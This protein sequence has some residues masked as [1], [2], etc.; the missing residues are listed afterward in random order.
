MFIHIT[1][2]DF[3][4]ENK[5][6][7]ILY[8]GTSMPSWKQTYDNISLLYLSNEQIEA[9]NYAYETAANDEAKGIKPEPILCIIDLKTLK[10]IKEIEFHPDWGGYEVDDNTTWEETLEKFG[11]FSISGKIDDI[12]SLFKLIKL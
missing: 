3:L 2:K 5:E 12:K 1:I 4:K 7:D 10:K 11:S 6:Y 8:H 9:K